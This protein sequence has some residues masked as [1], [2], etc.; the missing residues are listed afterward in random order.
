SNADRVLLRDG[1]YKALMRAFHEAGISWVDCRYDDCGDRV[2]VLAPAEMPK[3]PFVESLPVA[4]AEA[5]RE[6][7]GAHRAQ[8]GIRLRMALHAGEINYDQYGVTSAAIN[9]T[10]RLLD[11]PPLRTALSGTPGLLALITSSCFYDAVV[12]HST[13]CDPTTFRPVRVKV[14]ETNTVGWISLPDH[15]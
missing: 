11:A 5:L 10:F 7:N 9:L 8:A 12:R 1:L 4:L 13:V 14:K 6:H 15:P 3:G 2:F